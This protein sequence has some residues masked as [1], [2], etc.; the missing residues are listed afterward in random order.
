VCNM[1]TVDPQTE[2][3]HELQSLYFILSLFSPLSFSAHVY[4]D[5]V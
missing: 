3:E 4:A 5:V 1:D 2:T